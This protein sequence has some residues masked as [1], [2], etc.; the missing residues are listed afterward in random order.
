MVDVLFTYL[1]L[2]VLYLFGKMK[3]NMNMALGSKLYVSFYEL[4]ILCIC[5]IPNIYVWY[6]VMVWW[7]SKNEEIKYLNKIDQGN[8][9]EWSTL[10]MIK[11]VDSVF[12]Y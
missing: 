5:L 10:I 9:C 7:E 2:H 4:E 1:L 3:N 12:S 8:D 6:V 11:K